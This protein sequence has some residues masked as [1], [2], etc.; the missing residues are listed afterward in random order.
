MG[1]MFKLT[2]VLNA[3]TKAFCTITMVDSK[4]GINLPVNAKN[5]VEC[6]S[7]R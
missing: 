7:L 3:L 5:N 6:R 1:K 4:H 2:N